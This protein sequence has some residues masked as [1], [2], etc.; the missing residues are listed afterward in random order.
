MN[1]DQLF[2]KR[3]KLA[4]LLILIVAFA[5]RGLLLAATWRSQNA[6]VGDSHSYLV[7]AESFASEGTFRSLGLPEIF[8]TPGYPLFLV[9]CWL[10]GPLS[11]GFAQIVQVL[12]SVATVYLTYSLAKQLVA[13][14]AALCAAV[15]QA[16]SVVSI[17]I[18]PLIVTECLYTFLFVAAF[19][20]LVRHLRDEGDVR[21]L[22]G[23][24]LLAAIGTYVKPVG[25]IWIP[26]VIFVLLARPRR[27]RNIGVFVIVCC[28]SVA[29]WYVRNASETG[30][31]GFSTVGDFNWLFYEA[32]GVW[33]RTHGI[34]IVDAQS[35]LNVRYRR[36]IAAR[37]LKSSLLPA[38]QE[39]FDVNAERN[40]GAIALERE[41]ANGII[42]THLPLFVKVHLLTSLGS[43]LPASNLLLEMLGMTSRSTGTLN[44]LQQRGLLAAW[45]WYFRA[46][47]GA[48]FLVL[49]ELAVMTI[50]YGGV[51]LVVWAW[52]RTRTHPSVAIVLLFVLTFAAFILVGGPASTA[53][54]RMPVEPLLNIAAGGGIIWLLN[55]HLKS[56]TK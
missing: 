43:L 18:C 40:P 4:L 23:S 54:M 52:F 3:A 13:R 39:P 28:L 38:K 37:N 2:P 15:L 22:I 51:L 41:M 35:D 9:F 47:G 31:R 11:F 21:F 56:S 34:S 19:Y 30:Y 14:A 29:P 46:N 24:A 27:L 10:S 1:S 36:E 55:T 45:N 25:M 50:Q 53:R 42:L 32:A 26:I 49:P 5:A 12:L 16:V 33:A 48:V 8:R 7:P 44:V 17:A 6:I 20:L